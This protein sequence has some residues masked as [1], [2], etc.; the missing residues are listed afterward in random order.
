MVAYCAVSDLLLGKIPTPAALDP[1]K[2]VQDAADEI[3]SKI[4]HLYETPIDLTE[5]LVPPPVPL[6]DGG[7][8]VSRPTRLLLKRINAH[9]A[10]GRLLLAVAAPEEQRQ[11]HAYAWSLVKEATAALDLIAAGD[12][13]LDGVDPINTTEGPVAKPLIS[14]LDAESNVESFYDRI[15]NPAYVYPLSER[16][17][18]MPDGLTL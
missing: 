13:S 1:A 4:G 8:K 14:N 15:A 3:D 10:S 7:L 9:L 12:I 6:V 16:M 17:Y 11:L 18:R 2:Y 5:L